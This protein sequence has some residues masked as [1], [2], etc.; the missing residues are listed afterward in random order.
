MFS[1]PCGIKGVEPFF[2]YHESDKAIEWA[3]SIIDGIPQA[4]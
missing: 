3:K 2:D 4:S 1:F